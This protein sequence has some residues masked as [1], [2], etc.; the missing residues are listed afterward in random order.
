MTKEE[1]A[2]LKKRI[3]ETIEKTEKE[4]SYLEDATK[5]ITPENS[6]GRVSRMDAINNKSVSEV[7][8]RSAR[9]KLSN[10]KIALHN[11]DNPTFGICS[12]CKRPIAPARLMFMPQSTR[13]VRCADR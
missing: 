2:E 4:L 13:C 5:P 11:I 6:I 12:N 7:A 8:L 1:R 3:E 9:K 10:L